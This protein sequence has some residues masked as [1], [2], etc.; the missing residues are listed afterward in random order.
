MLM[1]C[2]EL[3]PSHSEYLEV[4]KNS[5]KLLMALINDI[6]DL[7]KIEAGQM[8][9]Q[10]DAFSLKRIL[11]DVS[12]NAKGLLSVSRED[13]KEITLIGPSNDLADVCDGVFGDSARIQQVLNVSI[14]GTT[15]HTRK[16]P[17]SYPFLVMFVRTSCQMPSNSRG[18]ARWNTVF[19]WWTMIDSEKYCSS[20]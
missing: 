15:P 3:T 14:S 17:L 18:K 8:C 16:V 12:S 1:E 11:G 7:S 2:E 6:L 9:V 13:A 4:I 10:S 20:L 5:G 19:V